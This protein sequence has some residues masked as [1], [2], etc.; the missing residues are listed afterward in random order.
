MSHKIELV[1][2]TPAFVVPED[3]ALELKEIASKLDANP[4]QVARLTFTDAKEITL[5]VKQAKSWAAAN[6]YVYGKRRNLTT[7][8]KELTFVL[9]PA[10]KAE[11]RKQELAAKRAERA[12][13]AAKT[14]TS[15]GNKKS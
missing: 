8:D 14:N 13:K 10:A 4:L 15:K 9:V 3:V 2:R 5:F 6:G 7:S 11:A 1:D 12:A